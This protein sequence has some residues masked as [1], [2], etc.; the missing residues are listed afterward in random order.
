MIP[1]HHPA[2]S[3][4]LEVGGL[5]CNLW[6]PVGFFLVG[7][8]FKEYFS[9][10]KKSLLGQ[11]GYNEI[12]MSYFLGIFSKWWQF[13][14]PELVGRRVFV[15]YLCKY[16]C[17]NGLEMLEPSCQLCSWKNGSGASGDSHCAQVVRTMEEN[18]A[19]ARWKPSLSP[20]YSV[21]N[22]SRLWTLNHNICVLYGVQ[23]LLFTA[24]FGH[25]FIVL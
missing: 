19:A 17:S 16:S 15:V 20:K 11:L 24:W 13:S 14:W 10:L 1:W 25:M 6:L 2:L 22:N 12:E 8:C 7:M 18:P 9:I 3:V 23:N 5:S 21:F 4:Y